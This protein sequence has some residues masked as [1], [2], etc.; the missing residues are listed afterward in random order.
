MFPYDKKTK[1]SDIWHPELIT[2]IISV[3]NKENID[4]TDT[5][6]WFEICIYCSI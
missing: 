1:Y 3:A 2:S 5:I 4:L 6:H